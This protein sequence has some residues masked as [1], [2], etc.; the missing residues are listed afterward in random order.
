[1][2]I[3][4]GTPSLYPETLLGGLYGEQ[5]DRH[6]WVLYTKA[7][8]EKAIV[9]ELF[10]YDVPYYLPL[11]K[12]TTVYGNRRVHSRVPLFSGYVFLFGT[13][14]E[15]VQALK[16]NRVSQVLPVA[17]SDRLQDDLEQLR[18][19]IECGAPLTV[20]SRLVNGD[21]VRIR[22]GPLSG[23]EGTVVNRRGITRLLVS[24]DFLQQ[25]ASVAL[26]DYMLET[27]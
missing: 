5:V 17:D 14:D 9:R 1:M 7:R 25:G 6:W 3:V 18:Q 26:D 11:V 20:E 8:Q 19:L 12:K 24:V 13:D 27:I 16:T 2:S 23:L 10:A 15:R 21:R 4:S 22:R